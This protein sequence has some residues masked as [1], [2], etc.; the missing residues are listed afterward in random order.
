MSQSLKQLLINGAAAT[1]RLHV[2]SLQING[3]DGWVD[4]RRLTEAEEDEVLALELQGQTVITGQPRQGEKAKAAGRHT[5]DLGSSAAAQ[6]KARRIAVAYALSVGG[7]RWSE[8][9]VGQLPPAAVKAIHD[10][11]RTTQAGDVDRL[12]EAQTFREDGPGSA[13]GAAAADGDT[14]GHD[15][16]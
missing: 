1:E 5:I 15:T 16:A 12:D 3:H 4:I 6:G 9:D 2:P 8:K 11:V 7:E 13:D 10:R 14:A